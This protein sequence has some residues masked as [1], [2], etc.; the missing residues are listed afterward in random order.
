VRLRPKCRSLE[1]TI[2]IAFREIWCGNGGWIH[3]AFGMPTANHI[4]MKVTLWSRMLLDTF[5]EFCKDYA[6][7]EVQQMA[8]YSLNRLV[9]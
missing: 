1:T 5:P 6:D 4:F 2:T 7:L 8:G 3:L 9:M